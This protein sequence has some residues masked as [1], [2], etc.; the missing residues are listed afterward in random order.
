MNTNKKQ[1]LGPRVTR[2]SYETL[3]RLAAANDCSLGHYVE[4][5]LEDH[6]TKQRHP[7]EGGGIVHDLIDQINERLAAYV[8][9]IR[10]ASTRDISAAVVRLEKQNEA[11]KV[12]IDAIVRILSPKEHEAYVKTVKATI[13]K[14]GPLFEN[15]N[16]K[17]Q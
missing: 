3:Q 12:M 2:E 16:G 17:L 15:G 8:Q 10:N 9:Q 14:L 6:V 1:Q 5:V 13:Q 7:D 4:A 11:L